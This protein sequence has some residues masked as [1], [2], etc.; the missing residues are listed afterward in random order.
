M[1]SRQLDRRRETV[2]DQFGRVELMQR[3]DGK[4]FAHNQPFFRG[5][6]ENQLR[7]VESKF[8]ALMPARQAERLTLLVKGLRFG[9]GLVVGVGGTLVSIPT[10]GLSLGFAIAGLGLCAWEAYDFKQEHG[11][12]GLKKRSF[13]R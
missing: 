9:A 5:L 6:L 1:P 4:G 8:A 10:G 12:D 13:G 3:P 2:P 7:A 11:A